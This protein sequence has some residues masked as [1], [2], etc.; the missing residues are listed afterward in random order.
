MRMESGDSRAVLPSRHLGE[1]LNITRWQQ[2]APRD[3]KLF[4]LASVFYPRA[5]GS[6]GWPAHR[7]ANGIRPPPLRRNCYGQILCFAS[8]HAMCAP[9][10]NPRPSSRAPEKCSIFNK[11]FSL[12]LPWP[13]ETP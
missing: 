13:R 2:M 6:A 1:Q 12:N 11:V 5:G 9:W 10:I 3:A 8:C 7:R 4:S